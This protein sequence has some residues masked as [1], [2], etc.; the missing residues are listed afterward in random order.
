VDF[1]P[2]AFLCFLSSFFCNQ[3]KHFFDF[4]L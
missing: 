4:K 3:L 2:A 1:I